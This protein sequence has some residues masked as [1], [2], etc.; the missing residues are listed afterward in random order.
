MSSESVENW[1]GR[2]NGATVKTYRSWWAMWEKWRAENGGRFAGMSPDE[3][4][5]YQK[6]C[7]NHDC[8]QILDLVQRW[9]GGMRGKA[10]NTKANYY[11]MVRSFFAHNRAELPKDKGF[12]IRGD[13]L[14]VQGQLGVEDIR[15]IC[16]RSRKSYRAIFLSMFQGAM[17]LE[18]AEYWNFN[19]WA[20]LKEQLDRGEKVIRIDLPGRK[21]V[22]NERPYYTLI[23]GDAVAAIR[24]YLGERPE[25][26]SAIFFNQYGEPIDKVS[27]WAYWH[28]TILALGL[29][30]NTGERSHRT[31]YNI[32]EMRDVFRSQWEKSAVK[33]I[34][35]EYLM[36]HK[37]DPLEYNKFYKDEDFVREQY[38][39]ALPMIQIMSG[40]EP[41]GLIEKNELKKLRSER[42]GMQA[43][44]SDLQFKYN[45]L[46]ESMQIMGLKERAEAG[47]I[48]KS[49]FVETVI[50]KVKAIEDDRL[51]KG[52]SKD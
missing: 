33:G 25:S 42:D 12:I 23:G 19:G 43:Q 3:L 48:S 52:G 4:V 28:R 37:V 39:A 35:G 15:N 40:A 10:R 50:K 32:H 47:E 14:P 30:S 26:D 29:A 1:I 49:D 24:D 46:I 36:G 38:E 11:K 8:Y 16:L 17:G 6:N 13:N 41:Y 21:K 7:V 44:I 9:V 31:G 5:E 2:M 18:E 22:R 45:A 20:S 51:K 34:V 27:M